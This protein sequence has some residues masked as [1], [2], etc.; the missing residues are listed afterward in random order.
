MFSPRALRALR[1]HEAG[2]LPGV[3]GGGAGGNGLAN[4]ASLGFPCLLITVRGGRGASPPAGACRFPAL[5]GPFTPLRP[6][7]S[8]PP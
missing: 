8:R 5:P 2:N 3:A 4:L 6:R 7:S 1:A